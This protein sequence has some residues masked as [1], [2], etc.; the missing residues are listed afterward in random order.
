M[1]G[2]T[3]GGQG[4]A[5]GIVSYI[6]HWDEGRIRRVMMA[7]LAVLSGL[8][9]GLIFSI[10]ACKIFFFLSPPSL[11]IDMADPTELQALMS[12][13]S[14][15]DFFVELAAWS[16][17]IL[18]GGYCAVRIGN[19]GPHLAWVVG[20]LIYLF[21]YQVTE[22]FQGLG[23]LATFMALPHPA[24][25]MGLSLGLGVAAAYVAGLLG[26][27]VNSTKARSGGSKRASGSKASK[28][29]AQARRSP[30]GYEPQA[31]AAALA[32]EPV[33]ETLYDTVHDSHEPEPQPEPQH[34]TQA[35]SQPA[36]TESNSEEAY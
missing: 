18:G 11:Y 20:A 23:V 16:V 36:S 33:A 31:A 12:T 3:L 9:L 13:V 30:L 35:E 24:W 17:A 32:A 5:Q 27:Y 1:V 7:T 22:P 6:T 29:R 28:S 21:P 4:F 15:T 26:S 8:L 2:K 19:M 34:E 10:L 25:V 14:S